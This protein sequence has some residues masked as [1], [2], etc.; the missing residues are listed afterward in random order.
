MMQQALNLCYMYVRKLDNLTQDMD[1]RQAG[2]ADYHDSLLA[3]LTRHD[4]GHDK[5]PAKRCPLEQ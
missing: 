4:L 5:A 2:E 3:D 1:C